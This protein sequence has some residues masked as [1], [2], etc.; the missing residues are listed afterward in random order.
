MRGSYDPRFDFWK[1]LRE[2]IRN[3][4]QKK[5]KLDDVLLS[6]TDP[7][8]LKRYPLAIRA[9]K[10]FLAKHK[11]LR[12]FAPP[13]AT[14]SYDGLNVRVNPELGLEIDGKK[15]VVKLYFKEDKPTKH[16]LKVVFEMMRITLPGAGWIPAVVDVSNGRLITPKPLEENLLPLLQ[17]QALAFMHLWKAVTGSAATA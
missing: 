4:H 14:W 16:R 8:K 17:A 5:T 3:S 11:N 9:Y 10:K 2:E 12:S 1:Q 7:K 15:Y 6:L 13:S